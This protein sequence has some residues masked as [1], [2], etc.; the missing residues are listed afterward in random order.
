MPSSP[1]FVA[2]NAFVDLPSAGADAVWAA[3]P[4]PA[5]RGF[6]SAGALTYAAAGLQLLL[7][8][9][10]L[11]VWLAAHSGHCGAAPGGAC[12]PAPAACV[13]CLLLASVQQ[14][15]A[16]QLPELL[17]QRRLVHPVPDA[18]SER[19]AAVFTV[20]LLSAMRAMEIAGARV[21]PWPGVSESQG[22]VT[23]LDRLF[24]F[25]IETRQQCSS[26]KTCS[27]TFTTARALDL[28]VPAGSDEE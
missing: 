13:A 3:Y 4:P 5:V 2:L 8:V 23:H 6:A 12:P 9:P 10:A 20:Q 14:L 28:A 27:S 15:G 17:R 7:R 11:I 22:P 21:A 1:E 25:A 19:D 24:G 16:N 26:C 18:V